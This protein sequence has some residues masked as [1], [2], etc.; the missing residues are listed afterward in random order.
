M[1]GA[2]LRE[3]AFFRSRIVAVAA[4]LYVLLVLVASFHFNVPLTPDRVVVLLLILAFTTGRVRTF[5]KDWSIFLVVLLAWQVLTSMSRNFGN[6]KPHVTEMIVVDKFLFF[7]HVPTLWLQEHFYH[8]G[9]L[10]WYDIAATILYLMHFAFPMG[11]AFA[12]WLFHRQVF[13][14]FMVAFLLVA[15]AGFATF[16]L[17]PAAPP[18][19]AANWWHYMPHVH[20]IL[21][22]G[23]DFFGGETSFSALYVWLWNHG[24]W[25]PFGAVPSE[26]AALPFLCFLYAR[27]AWPRGGWLLL[28]YCIAV[29]IAVVYL[30]EHYVVDVIAG[31]LYA[32]AGYIAV[33]LIVLYQWS[34]T[35]MKPVP[36]NRPD[37]VSDTLS[38]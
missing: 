28:P 6:F 36:G 1:R 18:W 37:T 4:G 11:V 17:Y 29:W 8:P 9:H 19:I 21:R 5:L 20:K 22:A 26:H 14:T 16:V 35:D 13:L 38:P 31:V 33:E 30:G 27:Q 15:L 23:I 12:L 3:G 32:A 2:V 7:G 34:R 24:G 10:A 25:D